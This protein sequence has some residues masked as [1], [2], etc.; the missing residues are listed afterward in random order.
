M[1]NPNIRRYERELK[2]ALRS[3]RLGKR[4][5]AAFAQS[6]A[7]LLEDI[8]N[9]S[10]DDL[11]DAFGPPE[12]LA[13]SL[14]QTVEIPQPLSLRKKLGLAICVILA[15]FAVGGI[16]I[17]VWNTPE[18][19]FVLNSVPVFP[20]KSTENCY[21][22]VDD[23]FTFS[24]SHWDQPREMASYLV[25]V[26]NTGTVRTNIF[27]TYSK[28]QPPH[29]FAVPAGETVAF[30]VNNPRLGPHSVAFDTPDGTLSGTVR[31][32]LSDSPIV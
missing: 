31:V 6:L 16:L 4:I 12:H 3:P 30:A 19:G 25:I 14:L 22:I 27:V 23:P 5:S 10:Y 11:V 15:I 21:F 17:S 28:H 24:D 26:Q 29:T 20:V 32:L 7:P 18:E 1:S 2:K 9:P 13:Q 8:P